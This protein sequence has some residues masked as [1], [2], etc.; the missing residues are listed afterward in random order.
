M[1]LKKRIALCLSLLFLLLTGCSEVGMSDQGLMRPPR[2]TGERAEIQTLISEHAASG[3]RLKYPLRGENRSAI[4]VFTTG[5]NEEYAA[6]LYSTDSDTMMN[7][8]LMANRDGSWRWLGSFS[9]ASTG[10]DQLILSDINKDGRDELF[11][12]WKTFTA[13]KNALTVYS[14]EN[15]QARE[16]AVEDSYTDVLLDDLTRGTNKDI[17]LLSLGSGQQPSSVKVLQYSDQEKRPIGKFAAELDPEVTAFVQVQTG[18]IDVGVRGL[19]VDGEKTGGVLTTQLFYYDQITNDLVEPLLSVGDSGLLT[20]PTTR[21]DTVTSRDIDEDGIIEVPVVSQMAASA[22]EKGSSVCSNTAWKQ[23]EVK[24]AELQVKLNTVIN[25]SDG[26]YFILPDPWVGNVTALHDPEKREILFYQWDTAAS[27][28]GGPLLSVRR[29]TASEWEKQ[30]SAAYTEAFT[31]DKS[32]PSAVIGLRIID[33]DAEEPM[34]LTVK[35][36]LYKLKPLSK[37]S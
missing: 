34:K 26:Y 13:S 1:N 22:T 27:T 24:K 18:D 29:F 7:V 10:V 9:K 2:A 14:F 21:K 25:D 3:Y 8:S 19:V 30:S 31:L 37:S 17:I 16:M 11:V 12:G 35:D 4:T 32:S 20:N 28:T 33:P 15:E 5:K 23:W 6:A 36:A